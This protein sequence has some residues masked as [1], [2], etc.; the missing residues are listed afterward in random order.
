MITTPSIIPEGLSEVE[1][2]AQMFASGKSRHEVIQDYIFHHAPPSALSPVVLKARGEVAKAQES[3]ERTRKKEE[4]ARRA[5]RDYESRLADAQK[6]RAE[7]AAGESELAIHHA[8]I[9]FNEAILE[10]WPHEANTHPRGHL[11]NARHALQGA[12][13]WAEFLPGWIARRKAALE[14]Y[15]KETEEFERDK[16]LIRAKGN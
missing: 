16:G 13:F 7:I 2:E 10:N 5:Q 4:A 3:L 12:K 15:E 8:N 9:K 6:Q 14:A 1:I 11:E